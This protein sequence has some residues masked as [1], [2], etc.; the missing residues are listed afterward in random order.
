[1]Q[2]R[3]VMAFLR[4]IYY[5][6]QKDNAL[7]HGAALAYYTLFSMAPLLML[8]IAIAGFVFGRTAAEGQLFGQ[9][10]GVIGPAGART[11]EGMI[12]SVST[13]K[14]GL[15][16]SAVSV[17]TILFG[18]S[19]VFGQLRTS[20]NHIWEVTPSKGGGMLGIAR[21]RLANFLIILGIGGLLLASLVLTAA[22]AAVHELLARHLPLLG[23]LLPKLNF[24]L[25]LA[26]TTTLFAMIY[27]ILPET[28]MDW[29]DVWLGAAV[30][31]VLFTIGK[32]LIG[33]YLGRTGVASIYGAAGS[34]VLVLLWV[35]Y[36]AQI[37]FIGAE[38][39]E[40]YSRRYGSR[41]SGSD[42][43]SLPVAT[44]RQGSGQASGSGEGQGGAV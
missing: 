12:A 13:P 14:A 2:T 18:A 31:A 33:V 9:I 17:V 7:S 10:E 28:R 37:F 5:Q 1:M 27:K 35:Y 41:R 23:G 11:V 16:A 22:L 15:I 19:A 6:W 8:I 40:V 4:E 30:T 29:R 32:T 34:L 43:G 42:P 38:F 20:L 21:Q 26:L 3:Q 25:S 24:L 39:T 44:L 36:C